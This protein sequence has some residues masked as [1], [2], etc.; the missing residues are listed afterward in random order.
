MLDLLMAAIVLGMNASAGQP[1]DLESEM[2][3]EQRQRQ[4]LARELAEL[5][6]NDPANAFT[7]EQIQAAVDDHFAK[8]LPGWPVRLIK[9]QPILTTSRPR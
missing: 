2:A 4:Q 3:N 8:P 7:P 9:S 1:V 5:Y 6:R